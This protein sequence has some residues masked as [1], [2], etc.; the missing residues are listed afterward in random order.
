VTIAQCL[1]AY[2]ADIGIRGKKSTYD[3]ASTHV[4]TIKAHVPVSF[5]VDAEKISRATVNSLIESLRQNG[6]RDTSINGVLRVLRAAL[7]L[8]GL[9]SPV[10]LLRETKKIPAILSPED[11]TRLFSAAPTVQ[12]RL[13]ITLAAEAGLRRTE[14]LT[15]TWADVDFSRRE[16]VVRAKPNWTPKSHAERAVP[17]NDRLFNVLHDN[18]LIGLDPTRRV[19]WDRDTLRDI[20]AAFVVAGLGDPALKPGLHMLRRTF[21]SRLLALGADIETVRELGGWADLATVQRYVA[22]TN[23]LKRAAV[24]RL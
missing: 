13:A 11:L 1:N 4:R 21:A 7:R 8:A 18:R 15:L 22:S 23:E 10:K 19:I 16:V 12:A 6:M 14:I 20:R 3:V 5:A 9:D 2:L 24:E 17:M